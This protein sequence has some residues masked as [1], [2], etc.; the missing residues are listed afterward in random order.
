MESAFDMKESS[1]TAAQRHSLDHD[2]ERLGYELRGR[3]PL[4][5]L[6]QGL[7]L[8]GRAWVDLPARLDDDGFR[9]LTPD[10]RGTGESTA[11]RAVLRLPKLADDVAALIDVVGGG[12]AAIVVGISLGG[13]IAQHVALRHPTRVRGLLLAATTPGLPYGRLASARTLWRLTRA[14]TTAPGTARIDDLLFHPR[15]L[16]ERP[17]LVAQWNRLLARERFSV[18]TMLGQLTAAATHAA[19]LSL[20]AISVATEV[21][22]GDSDVLIPPINS[23]VMAARMPHARLTVVGEG[24]HAFPLEHPKVLPRLISRLAAGH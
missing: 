11:R 10:N 23:R 6:I 18:A 20:G 8:S 7:G 1:S 22:T 3:G 14:C 21:V 4:V 17:E 24:G 15:T 13:M 9:V 12:E 19:G 5:V 16:D 2:G